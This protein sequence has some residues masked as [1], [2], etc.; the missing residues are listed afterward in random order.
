MSSYNQLVCARVENELLSLESTAHAKQRN[1]Y[2]DHHEQSQHNFLMIA[3]KSNLLSF[4]AQPALLSLA[5]AVVAAMDVVV[6]AAAVCTGTG[7]KEGLNLTPLTAG[8]RSPPLN[9]LHY[10]Y[11]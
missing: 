3:T 4:S 1:L 7:G 10:K 6:D 2:L 5:E 11:K 8:G 9:H